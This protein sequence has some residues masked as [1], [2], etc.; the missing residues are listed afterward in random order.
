[1]RVEKCDISNL[2]KS[3]VVD[4][5]WYCGRCGLNKPK[6]TY[7]QNRA[8]HLCQDCNKLY[9]QWISKPIYL[10][11]GN[12]KDEFCNIN[13]NISPD[14]VIHVFLNIDDETKRYLILRGYGFIFKTN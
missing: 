1:M 6:S 5:I 13:I 3:T 8:K 14:E 12:V 7:K 9:I 11:P 4:D 10:N 2:F